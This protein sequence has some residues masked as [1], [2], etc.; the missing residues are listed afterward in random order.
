MK[1]MLDGV[2]VIDFSTTVAGPGCCYFMSDMGAE[3]IK[4]EKPGFGDEARLFPPYKDGKSASFATLNHGK[5]GAVIDAKKPEGIALFKEL[6]SA[7]DVLVENMIPGTMKKLGLDF[8]TLSKVN[9]RLI[10]CSISGFGQYGPLS[11]LP[12]YDAVIQAASGL[13]STTGY[14]DRPP[15]RTG[16]LIIDIS[17]AY[18]A[19]FAVCAALYAREKTGK[20]EHLDI[21]MYDVGINLLESKFIEYTV[22]GNIP[23]PTGNRFGLITPFDTFKTSDSYVL[24][25][26]IS[27]H[28]WKSLCAGMDMP[29]LA[30]D[31]RFNNLM[32][33][34]Q[35]EAELKAIIEGWSTKHT[36]AEVVELLRDSG[37]PVGPVNNVKEVVEHP[38]TK[39]RGMLVELP[40]AGGGSITTFGPSV[41]AVN[42]SVEVRGPAPELGQD[43][44]WLLKEVLKKSD[45]E[46]ERILASKIMG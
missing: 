11:P 38:H 26:C 15:L 29:A 16:T 5:R 22:S 23:Q 31:P 13:M 9:P 19:S 4:I 24:I 44:R 34:N 40:L 41:K 45:V 12:G 36:T 27:D 8:E 37:A 32:V 42:T 43:N 35:N 17:T 10:M 33:R 20:G 6:V 39:A 28:T 14:P 18:N 46:V 21:A 2:R 30:D 3:V 7:S 1:G 25:I